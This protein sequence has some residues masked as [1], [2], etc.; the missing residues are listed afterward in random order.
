[1]STLRPVFVRNRPDRPDLPVS[2]TLHE[3]LQLS[4]RAILLPRNRV[5]RLR[6]LIQ[7]LPLPLP[8]A[9]TDDVMPRTSRASLS[10]GRLRPRGDTHAASG[11]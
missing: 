3:C 6:C 8:H 1:M 2:P 10:T 5:E 4:K 7:L 11:R 9:L